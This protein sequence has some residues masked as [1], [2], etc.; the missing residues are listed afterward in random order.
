MKRVLIA[1]IIAA[2]LPACRTISPFSPAAYQQAVD[3]KVDSLSLMDEA[4]EPYPQHAAEATQIK[5]RMDKAYEFARGRA[6]NEISTRQWEIMKSTSSGLIG[7]FLV[8]W[9]RKGQIKPVAIEEKKRLVSEG[10]DQI[11]GLESG[12]GRPAP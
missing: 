7:E 9:Q 10:F 11:I 6:H 3:L 1:L 5:I 4:T 12:K 8:D 2:G